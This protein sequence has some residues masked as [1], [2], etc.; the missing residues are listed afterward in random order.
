MLSR[1]GAHLNL[2]AGALLLA[3]CGDSDSAKHQELDPATYDGNEPAPGDSADT[4][5]ARVPASKDGAAGHVEAAHPGDSGSPK[6]ALD[7]GT[8]QVT[9]DSDSGAAAATGTGTCCSDGNCLCHGP[10]PV[11]LTS[12]PGPYKTQSYALAN[13]GCVFYPTDAEPPFAA[14]TVSDGFGGTGGCGALSQTGQWG[15]LYASW[16]IVTMI[17]DTGSGD[18]PN[19]RGQALT[20]GITAFK[21]ENNKSGS[22]LQGKLSG[23]YGT[24]GFSMGGG[25]TTYASQSDPTLLSSVA[26][27][28]WGPVT[29]GVTVPTLVICGSS[30][31]IA[32]CAQHGTPAY[33]GIADSVPKMRVQIN[34]THAGQPSS[35]SGMSGKYGLA[36]TKTFLE[37]DQR[38][39]PL[40]VGAMSEA[41]NIK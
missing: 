1:S 28:P 9:A 3:A 15:P 32:P 5:D 7:A 11:A 4:H 13:A 20:K 34:S 10:D 29:K 16:G 26:I 24:S 17:V 14:V 23:R 19:V 36:F 8:V 40:L 35:A 12:Q 30:D 21:A 37:G 41:S 33:Q 25:G 39:R 2:I 38:W 31:T 27:M 18:Q 22:P 6:S